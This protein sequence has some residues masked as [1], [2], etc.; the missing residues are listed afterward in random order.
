[1]KQQNASN[2]NMENQSQT[3]DLRGNCANQKKN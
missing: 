1:M 3:K 2:N